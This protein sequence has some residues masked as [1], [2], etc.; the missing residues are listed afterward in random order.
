MQAC[1]EGTPVSVRICERRKAAGQR[2]HAND[3]IAAFI[4]SGEEAV[5]QLADLLQKRMQPDGL[6]VV[7]EA[8]HFCMTWRG[9]KDIEAQMIDSGMRGAFLQDAVPRPEF[10]S[11]LGDRS[12]RG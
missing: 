11:L 1:D 4:E 6:A 9:V 7:V 2:F 5:T 3:N 8:E 12:R 10:L